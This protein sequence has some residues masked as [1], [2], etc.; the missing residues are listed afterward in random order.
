[1]RRYIVYASVTILLLTFVALGVSLFVQP[2]LPS[3]INT[4]LVLFFIALLAVTGILA[5]FKDA[6]ELFRWIGEDLRHVKQ[7]PLTTHKLIQDND[8]AGHFQ[9]QQKEHLALVKAVPPDG[10]GAGEIITKATIASRV[11]TFTVVGNMKVG[12]AQHFS[13]LLSNGKILIAGGINNDGTPPQE[14][15]STGEIFD[16]ASR[17]FVAKTRMLA[18]R[19]FSAI[20]L[21][22]DNTILV[23]GGIGENGEVLDSVEI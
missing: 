1:M 18:R 2:L 4:G 7:K 5:N 23:T 11:L 6:L 10:V 20:T 12:R 3:G 9:V 13:A 17:S 21:L 16:P 22:A 14:V 19:Y 15:L 8:V